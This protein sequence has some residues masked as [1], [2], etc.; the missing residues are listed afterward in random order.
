MVFVDTD[1]SLLT[2]GWEVDDDLALLFLLGSPEVEIVGI[3]TSYGNS[4]GSLTNQDARKLLRL[5]GRSDIPIAAGAGFFARDPRPTAGSRLL[6]ES[7][8]QN[9]GVLSILTL[10]PLTNLAAAIREW[11]ELPSQVAEIVIMGGRWRNGLSDFNFRADPASARAV[12]ATPASKVVIPIDLCLP[13]VVTPNFVSGLSGSGESVVSQFIPK[14]RR[15]ARAQALFR[16]L[17]GR[18]DGQATGGFHPWDA[19]AAAWLVDPTLFG[20]IREVA[21]E[22]DESGRSALGTVGPGRTARM[23][24]GLDGERFL[25]LFSERLSVPKRARLSAV[26]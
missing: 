2:W 17:Q 13:V 5:C 15:F 19:I 4:L 18:V 20:D 23:P 1:P 21:L 7:V 16:T 6:I 24:F 25:T 14:L 11:P 22:I 3:S 8:R 12:L 26:I 9:P 10:A